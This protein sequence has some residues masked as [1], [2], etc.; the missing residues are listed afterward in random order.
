LDVLERERR[1]QD[2]LKELP[3]AESEKLEPIDTGIQARIAV[4]QNFWDLSISNIER[5]ERLVSRSEGTAKVAADQRDSDSYGETPWSRTSLVSCK[6]STG[7]M[8][9]LTVSQ[10]NAMQNFLAA[11]FL[12]LGFGLAAYASSISLDSG[13]KGQLSDADYWWL[14]QSNVMAVLGNLMTIVSLVQESW[15]SPAYA[16]AYALLLA[17]VLCSVVSIGIY[18]LLNTAFSSFFAVA[19]S[20]FSV[21]SVLIM[22]QAH[23]KV[24]IGKA[25]FKKD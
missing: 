25:K 12:V 5:D 3:L 17:S 15:W 16:L 11:T 23:A 14:W 4:L 21:F 19:G 1:F 10:Q 9:V 24:G 22:T 2:L 6:S 20:A 8:Y 18:T 7:D 13:G